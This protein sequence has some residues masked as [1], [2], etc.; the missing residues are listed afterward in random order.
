M[1]NSSFLETSRADCWE[2]PLSV[3]LS[4]SFFP[5]DLVLRPD[6]AEDEE[7]EEEDDEE[8]DDEELEAV[9]MDSSTAECDETGLRGVIGSVG[10]E[11]GFAS[12]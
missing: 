8:E 11:T 7:A 10:Q 4:R 2:L 9:D 3:F 6:L 1:R 12:I 5:L